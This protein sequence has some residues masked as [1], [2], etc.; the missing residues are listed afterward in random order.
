MTVE[1]LYI[2]NIESGIRVLKL[3]TK[4]PSHS[5]ILHNL[6]KLKEVNDGLYDDYLVK[7]DK[8]LKEYNK[9]NEN[10]ELKNN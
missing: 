6:K 3:K 7:Y 4:E 8:A 9:H 5:N 10:K 2:K 1:E